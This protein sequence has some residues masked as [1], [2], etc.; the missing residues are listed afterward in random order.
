MM[1]VAAVAVVLG[2]L[3]VA[4]A[5]G[6]DSTGGDQGGTD[7]T[8][9]A[10]GS[11]A[12]DGTAAP[13]DNGSSGAA[14][15]AT[16]AASNGGDG[17]ASSADAGSKGTGSAVDCTRYSAPTTKDVCTSCKTAGKT[18]QKNGCYGGYYCEDGANCVKPVSGC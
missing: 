14:S 11:T 15:G 10:A 9:Q 6:T 17:G 4:C 13:T 16:P 1:R 18:C 3:G 5:T 2:L 7:P 8:A 12:G